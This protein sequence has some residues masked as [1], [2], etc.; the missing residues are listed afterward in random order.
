MEKLIKGSDV[1]GQVRAQ[2]KSRFCDFAVLVRKGHPECGDSAFICSDEDNLV[3]GVFDGVSGEPGAAFASS[4]A[5][6]AMLAH[7]KKAAKPSEAAMKAALTKAHLAIRIGYT[8]VTLLHMHNDGSFIIASIG[9]SP[10]YGIGKNGEISLELPLDRAV[11]DGDSILKYFAYRNMVTC[12]LG[13]QMELNVHVLSGK[14]ETGHAL[15]LATDGL[16]DNLFAKVHNGYVSD[17][18]GADDLRKLVGPLRLPSAIL[19]TLA[20]AAGQRA[21]GS[22]VEEPGRMLVPKEDDIALI[23]VRRI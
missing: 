23:V 18:S 22:N 12:V 14:L 1:A 6:E 2:G 10:V 9:D 19:R 20:E 3:A 16:S 4:D 13:G 17:S 15:I 21:R 8:T 5:A 11:K 7:L